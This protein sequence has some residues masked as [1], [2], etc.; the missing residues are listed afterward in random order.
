MPMDRLMWFMP[1]AM[2]VTHCPAVLAVWAS[3]T[4]GADAR[5]AVLGTQVSQGASSHCAGMKT[6][7]VANASLP[8]SAVWSQAADDIVA[9]GKLTA[10]QHRV[11]VLCPDVREVPQSE[12]RAMQLLEKHGTDSV[13]F[14]QVRTSNMLRLLVSCLL[15]DPQRHPQLHAP[16]RHLCQ[17]HSLRLLGLRLFGCCPLTAH[18]LKVTY[19][20]PHLP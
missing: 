12:A 8:R 16:T 19:N 18:A 14:L 2:S 7:E 20:T 9:A 3:E 11:R 10:L 17:P 13:G 5:C 15:C 6:A 4:S 1:S